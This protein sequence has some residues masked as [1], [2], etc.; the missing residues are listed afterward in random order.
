M[1]K[2]KCSR[3]LGQ[4]GGRHSAGPARRFEKGFYCNECFILKCHQAIMKDEELET[5]GLLRAG[6]TADDD[7]DIRAQLQ[8]MDPEFQIQR[9]RQAQVNGYGPASLRYIQ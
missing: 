1:P 4:F 3:C 6:L 2:N 9:V 8:A 5:G 7:A